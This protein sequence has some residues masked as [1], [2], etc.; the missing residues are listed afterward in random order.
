M[1]ARFVLGIPAR[2]VR[3]PPGPD[4][5]GIGEVYRNGTYQSLMAPSV[6]MQRAHGYS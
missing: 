3:S 1:A 6:R 5:G 2:Q 4:L